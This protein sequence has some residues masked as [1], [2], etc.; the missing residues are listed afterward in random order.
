ME[1]GPLVKMASFGLGSKLQWVRQ[2][3]LYS[4]GARLRVRSTLSGEIEQSVA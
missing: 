1:R 4:V 2:E 3:L